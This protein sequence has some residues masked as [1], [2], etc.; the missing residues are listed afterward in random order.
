MK[1]SFQPQYHKYKYFKLEHVVIL[2]ICTLLFMD[3]YVQS[4]YSVIEIHHITLYLRA[5]SLIF[6]WV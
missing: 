5:K 4:P 3:Y 6:A 2:T 1:F